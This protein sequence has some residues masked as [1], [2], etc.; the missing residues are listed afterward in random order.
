[1]IC[2]SGGCSPQD[3]RLGDLGARLG[4][5]LRTGRVTRGQVGQWIRENL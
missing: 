1:M 5:L 4:Y 3:I 2:P